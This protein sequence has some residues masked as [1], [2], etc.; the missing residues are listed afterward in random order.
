[1]IA[2]IIEF[3]AKNRFIVF[4][5]IIILTAWGIWAILKTP[6][7]AIP[8]LSDTQVIIYTE[9]QGRNPDLVE[10][11][12]TY[13]IASALLAAPGVRVTRGYSYF[14]YSFVYV[15]FKDGTDIY[16]ARSR[17]LEYLSR[18]AGVLPSGVTPQ[19]GPDA[20]GIGWIYQYALVDKSGMHD[21]SELRSIQDWFLR[22]AIESVE[23]V[24]EVAPIGGFVKEYQVAVNPVRLSAYNI[25]LMTVAEAVRGGNRDVGGRSIEFG[26][27]E[28]MVRGKGY[29]KSIKDI[30]NITVGTDS[31]GTPVFIKDIGKVS[32]VPAMRRGAGELDGKG[33]TVGGIVVM[34]Y[35]Q[36]ALD[37]IERVKKRLKI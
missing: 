15:I 7:D 13:P 33:E 29:I 5:M 1:M 23:G 19:L 25:P 27:R 18:I 3:S 35:G 8:D 4:L 28:F 32:L 10:D 20:T 36:H 21:L 34:R 22:Y 24:A 6:L 31:R 12:I 2:R 26:G 17:V 37:V 30:E 16:W 11:Q 9:W 14:G